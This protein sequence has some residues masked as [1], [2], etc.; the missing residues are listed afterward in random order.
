MRPT[1]RFGGW[2]SSLPLAVALTAGLSHPAA[3]Q[4]TQPQPRFSQDLPE[5]DFLF[6]RPKGLVRIAGGL[7][8]PAEN[9]DLFTFIQDQLTIDQGDFKSAFFAFDLGFSVSSRLDVVGGFDFARKTVSSEYRDY[10]DNNLLPIQQ[11]TSLR[12]S[13]FTG[14]LRYALLPRGRAVG[15]Y[16]WIPTR[17]QPYVGGGGGFVFWEFKQAGDFV[18][19]QDFDVFTDTFVSSGA[20]LSGHVLGG[21]DIQLYKRLFLNAEGR[22][23]WANGELDN[24]F[25]GFEPLDL[26]GFKIGG[27]I[28]VVF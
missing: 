15:G 17:V 1:A 27:G 13:T 14:S 11:D 6:R 3:A 24:D 23:M 12:Q 2:L 9:S 28:T 8:A 5:D 18:D 21:V 20:S 22:Y 4:N 10:V 7:L 26:S 16:A 25:V 19:F